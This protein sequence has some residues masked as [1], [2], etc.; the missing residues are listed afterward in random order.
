MSVAIDCITD[1]T[2]KVSRVPS[3][4][5][6]AFSIVT[7]EDLLDTSKYLKLP[8]VGIMYEGMQETGDPSRQGMMAD[9]RIAIVLVIDGSVI[10]NAD[11]K[12]EAID[13]LD[14]IRREI[15]MT[16]PPSQH[17]WRFLSETPL[18]LV[19]SVLIYVQRWSTPVALTN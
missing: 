2:S 9:C 12:N 10:G 8:A 14:A 3:L 4:V 6:K 17:K 1:I 11:R 15:R 13:T 18:G 16:R 7:E 19:G 5:G